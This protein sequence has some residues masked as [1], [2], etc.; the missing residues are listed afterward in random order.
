MS[1]AVS[2]HGVTLGY[3]Q[4][5]SGAAGTFTTVAELQGD[6]SWPELMR[7]SDEATPHNDD[8]D[9]YVFSGRLSRGTFD[10]DVYFV[11]DD[12]THDFSTGLPKLQVDGTTFGIRL[13]GPGGT[14]DTDEWIMS[15]QIESFQPTAPSPTGARAAS[16]TFRP[17]GKMK[18]DGSVIGTTS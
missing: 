6:I 7:E 16:F 12:A 14:D 10:F 9:S 8:I 17:S 2:G 13:R 3:E 1:Q 18:V 15:G 5:P 4:D 11:H